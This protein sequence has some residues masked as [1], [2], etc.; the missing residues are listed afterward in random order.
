MINIL[1]AIIAVYFLIGMHL[2]KISTDTAKIDFKL[3]GKQPPSCFSV[4]VCVVIITLF[5]LPIQLLGDK[6]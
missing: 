5:W 6:K 3:E 1:F 2:A 4:F